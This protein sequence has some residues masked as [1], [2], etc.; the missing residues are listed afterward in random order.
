MIKF[1]GGVPIEINNIVPMESIEQIN[2]N[3]KTY[4]G[5]YISYNTSS[6]DYGCDTTALVIGQGQ[7]FFIL[8]GNHIEEY[9][10]VFNNGFTACYDYFLN[11]GVK[12]KFSDTLESLQKWE[13]VYKQL[14]REYLIK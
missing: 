2:M 12:S 1:F 6:I 11:N 5:F 3:N 13:L 8:E 7:G 10:K 9:K 4:D 14:S